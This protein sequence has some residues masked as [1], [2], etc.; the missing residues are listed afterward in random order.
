MLKNCKVS[1][2][3]VKA[4]L[5]NNKISFS[6]IKSI[7]SPNR[8]SCKIR[9]WILYTSN[10]SRA[11]ISSFFPF[12]TENR[13]IICLIKKKK[14]TRTYWMAEKMQYSIS[15]HASLLHVLQNTFSS[16]I[17]KHCSL[18]HFLKHQNRQQKK[19]SILKINRLRPRITI[20]Y[21]I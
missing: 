8:D 6:I 16:F 11:I 17:R 4:E 21:L 18:I 1:D 19:I 10:P 3:T 7:L 5:K 9:S 12:K 2:S 14:D 15:W 13:H 20:K